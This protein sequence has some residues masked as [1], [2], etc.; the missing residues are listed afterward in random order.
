MWPLTCSINEIDTEEKA[1]FLAMCCLFYSD[2]KP[3]PDT[4]LK[5]FVVQSISFFNVRFLCKD[6]DGIE[7]RSK[8]MFCVCIADAP[9]RAMLSNLRQY[10]GEYGCVHCIHPGSRARK[11]GGT[12]Q[13]YKVTHPI[14]PLRDEDSMLNHAEVAIRLG[15]PVMGVKGPSLLNRVPGFNVARG[16]SPDIM[17]CLFLGVGNQFILWRLCHQCSL[18]YSA[19]W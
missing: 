12:V 1:N 16:F 9:A 5:P 3:P 14:H 2:S 13:I 4:F 17:H 11:K 10:N 19:F 6:S 15:K 8:V 7:R 18:L